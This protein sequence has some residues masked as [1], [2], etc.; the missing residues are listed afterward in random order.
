MGME[1]YNAA[2]QA[3]KTECAKRINFFHDAQLERLSEQLDELFSDPSSMVQVS[4]NIVKKIISNLSMVYSQPP[5]R[6]LKGTEKDQQIYA[7]ILER[8]AFDSKMKQA[9]RYTKLLKTIL[10]RPVWRNDSIALDILTGNILDVVTGESPELLE[11]VLITDYGTS[12]KIEDIQYSLWTPEQWQ[13][14]DYRG[15][16][17][18]EAENPY[19]VL[20]FV[21]CFDFPPLNSF[22]VCF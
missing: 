1:F 3:R 4:L 13:R 2:N 7:D 11:K 19:R 22:W 20:P 8:S 10:L 21:A 17:I 5:K 16:V 14:L 9:Q 12:G 15:F 6:T 18:D